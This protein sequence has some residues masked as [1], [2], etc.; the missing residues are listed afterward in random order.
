[1]IQRKR[2]STH[3]PVMLVLQII[4][5]LILVE[6]IEGINSVV[7]GCQRSEEEVLC[8]SP[9]VA[10]GTFNL[11][12][13]HSSMRLCKIDKNKKRIMFGYQRESNFFFPSGKIEYIRHLSIRLLWSQQLSIMSL[14][15]AVLTVMSQLYWLSNANCRTDVIQTVTHHT[16]TSVPLKKWER[17]FQKFLTWLITYFQR[18]CS[19]PMKSDDPCNKKQGPMSMALH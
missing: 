19:S 1:M 7:P 2:G 8:W 15:S 17:V 9:R 5:S 3:R 10:W 11:L 4:P 14:Q 16:M 18:I 6:V 13:H 12:Q